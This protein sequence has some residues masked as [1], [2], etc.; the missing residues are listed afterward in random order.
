[1]TAAGAAA[2]SPSEL[3]FV[4]LLAGAG[5]GGA[6][7]NAAAL[8]A[9]YVPRRYRP[10]AVTLTIV[11]VPLGA[12]MAGLL[13]IHVMPLIGWRTLFFVGGV[14]PLRD[15]AHPVAHARRSRRAISCVIRDAGPSSLRTLGRMGHPMPERRDLHRRR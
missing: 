3:A 15:R 13:G 2:S 11:C 4:R 1:M 9:E 12:T 7:P 14:V 8:A 10:V 5:L 6:I